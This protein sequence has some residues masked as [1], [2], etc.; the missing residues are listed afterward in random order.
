MKRDRENKGD[1]YQVKGN[2][3]YMED[4]KIRIKYFSDECLVGLHKKQLEKILGKP[5]RTPPKNGWH[6]YEYCMTENCSHKFQVVLDS[7]FYVHTAV[8]NPEATIRSH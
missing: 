7:F 4:G 8:L 1:Y 2:P 5:N 3:R 6:L